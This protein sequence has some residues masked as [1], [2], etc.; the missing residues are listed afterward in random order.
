VAAIAAG[1]VVAAADVAVIAATVVT[2]A[3]AGK[4]PRLSPFV[5]DSFFD[6]GCTI[7]APEVFCFSASGPAQ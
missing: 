4:F 3:T 6:F 1:A 7:F 2:A 5:F